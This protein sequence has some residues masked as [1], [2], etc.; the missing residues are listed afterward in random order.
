MGVKAPEILSHLSQAL[1]A[2]YTCVL[3]GWGE[4][5]QFGQAQVKKKHAAQENLTNAAVFQILFPCKFKTSSAL[6]LQNIK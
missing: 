4:V 6:Q 2:H 1:S 5:N 3:L